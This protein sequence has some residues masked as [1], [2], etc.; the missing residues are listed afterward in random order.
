MAHEFLTELRDLMI[1]HDID[2]IGF[3]CDSCSDWHGVTGEHMSIVT[4][5][6][7]EILHANYQTHLS[8][9]DLTE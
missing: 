8:V 4:N 9:N 5:K 7:E 3:E 2:T 1:K 6:G